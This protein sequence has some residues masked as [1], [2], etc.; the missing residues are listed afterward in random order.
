MG[1][2]GG[3]E[4]RKNGKT[5]LP[6][7][8]VVDLVA[9]RFFDMGVW[10]ALFDHDTL[11]SEEPYATGSQTS[12]QKPPSSRLTCPIHRPLRQPQ[13]CAGGLARQVF[14]K[15]FASLV[16]ADDRGRACHAT[17]LCAFGSLFSFPHAARCL[18]PEVAHGVCLVRAVSV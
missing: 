11:S 14:L 17:L 16:A 4:N 6:F 1:L 2:D 7:F 8:R 3:H 13:G 10:N 18:T 12:T 5:L 9:G 15:L